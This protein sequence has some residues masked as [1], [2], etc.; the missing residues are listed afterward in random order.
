M[1]TEL[2]IRAVSQDGMRVLAGDGAHEIL[3]D[4]PLTADQPVAGLTPLQALLASLCACSASTIRLLLERKMRQPV[5]GL[6]VKAH[7][8]RRQLRVQLIE[9]DSRLDQRP[10]LLR[11]HL[12]QA[13]EIF[14]DVNLDSFTNGLTGLRSAASTKGD[15]NPMVA[16]DFE[17]PFDVSPGLGNYHA[18]RLDPVDAGVSGIKGAGNDVEANFSIEGGLQFGLKE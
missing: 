9:H 15:G 12:Q 14:G 6:G 17:R 7:A 2:S 1:T 16:A 5:L 4:Y 18:Q 11:I 3:M 13:V 10:S 8:L